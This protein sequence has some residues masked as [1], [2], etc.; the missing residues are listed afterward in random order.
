MK[1]IKFL[2]FVVLLA[3][4]ITL[5]YSCTDSCDG[6]VCENGGACIDGTCDCPDGFSGA[7]CELVAGCNDPAA[8]NYSADATADDGSCTFPGDALV[9]NWEVTETVDGGAA[10]TYPAE[11]TRVDDTNILISSTRSSPPEYHVASIPLVVDWSEKTLDYTGTTISGTITDEN[12]F[13]LAYL[14]GTLT[15]V[16][17]VEQEYRR[18]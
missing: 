5:N 17:D 3:S 15:T 13:E 14:F 10:V 16:Y 4:T 8:I 7:N 11:V 2:G 1:A 18:Q 6:V 9:G 12:Y